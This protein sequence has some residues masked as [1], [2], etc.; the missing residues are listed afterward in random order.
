LA[1]SYFLLLYLGMNHL[2]E[3][4]TYN[5]YNFLDKILILKNYFANIVVL[6]VSHFI[7][8]CF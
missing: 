4:N 5:T 8:F 3:S 1:E 6:I 7:C 2:H